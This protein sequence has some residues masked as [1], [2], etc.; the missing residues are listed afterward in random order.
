[1]LRPSLA[2]LA[3][4]LLTGPAVG[5]FAPAADDP[6]SRPVGSATPRPG[7]EE[8]DGDDEGHVAGVLLPAGKT[9]KRP[10]PG[11]EP[12]VVFEKLSHD[13]GT[14]DDGGTYPVEFPFRNEGK[15]PLEI[16]NIRPLCA[17]TI[18]GVEVEGRPY[19]MGTPIEVGAKGVIRATLRPVNI[20][21]EKKTF[22]DVLTNDPALTSSVEAPFGHQRLALRAQ[23]QR[24]FEFEAPRPVL[25]LGSIA[26]D[27]V[28]DGE[29]VLKNTKGVP[30]QVMG[31]LP[32]DAAL[33]IGAE[34]LDATATR[35]RI[36][37]RIAPGQPHGTFV[38]QVE[39][40]TNPPSTQARFSVTARFRGLVD[41]EPPLGIRWSAIPR[42][43]S[44]TQSISVHAVD[45][46][47]ALRV[48]DLNLWD[49]AGFQYAGGRYLRDESE[50]PRPLAARIADHLAVS[51][52]D[53]AA[54]ERASIDV[55]VGPGMPPGVFT[56]M[57]V[58]STG[59]ENGPRQFILPITGI[60]R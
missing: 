41:V 40:Q 16:V 48:A 29:I 2:L 56:A 1:M 27:R 17:C 58:F 12:R 53:E 3:A 33:D 47:G 5:G 28:A 55:T 35:W 18:S 31:F 50:T 7:S 46:P 14:V 30:F 26:N 32:P 36:R 38:R 15:G 57:L 6:A 10:E 20:T 8:K 21:G 42:G 9:L 19:E 49:S 24:A 13:F 52:R 54:G 23:V 25:E 60:V 11:H 43:K 4:V 37:V 39:V 59:V 22:V 45:A 34:A 44:V 51:V